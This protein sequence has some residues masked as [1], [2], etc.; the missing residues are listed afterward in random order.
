[1]GYNAPRRALSPDGTQLY[2]TVPSLGKVYAVRRETR[3]IVHTLDT[4]G[5]SR[6]V[7]FDRSGSTVVIS[8]EAGW[9]D[10]VR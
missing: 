6:R 4:G 1:M 5:T 8:N 9:V 10:F 3:R 2:V 7:A